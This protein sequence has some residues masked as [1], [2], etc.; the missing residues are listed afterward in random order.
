MKDGLP[1]GQ[2]AYN[3]LIWLAGMR[4]ISLEPANNLVFVGSD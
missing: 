1:E 3:F 2:A 4:K